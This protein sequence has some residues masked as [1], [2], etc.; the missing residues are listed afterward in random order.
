MRAWQAL[1]LATGGVAGWLGFQV[2]HE[3]GHILVGW[4]TGARLAELVLAPLEISW[5]A[6]APNPRPLLV[7]W[8]GPGLGALLPL[9][10]WGL[11]QAAGWRRAHLARAFA[12]FCLLANGAYLL[13]DAF[14]RTGDGGTLLRHGAAV[15][16]LL[17]F[18]LLAVPAGLWCWRGL[19]PHFGRHATRGDAGLASALAALLVATELMLLR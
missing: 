4:W 14:G 5:S 7:A 19:G 8:G 15:W 3:G 13:V 10:A 1:S 6:F 9:A 18:G 17:A 2:V 16:Q 12:G 11:L